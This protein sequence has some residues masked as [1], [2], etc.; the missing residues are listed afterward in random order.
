MKD[1]VRAVQAIGMLVAFQVGTL[2]LF[3]A[4]L[5]ADIAVFSGFGGA[6][7]AAAYVLLPVTVVLFLVVLQT[8]FATVRPGRADPSGVAV[9]QQQ[10]PRL[11]ARA[12][13]IAQVAGTRPPDEI[14]IDHAPNA[15]VGEGARLLGLVPGR[16]RLVI[17]APLLLGLSPAEFDAVL[18]HEFGH[19][20]NRDTRLT[21]TVNRGRAAMAAALGATGG[22]PWRGVNG[23]PRPLPGQAL[24][25]M[26]VRA[27][28]VRYLAVTKAIGRRQEY[29]ADR[30]AAELAGPQ[31]TIAALLQ[32][33]ALVPM[34]RF[35]LDGFALSGLDLGLAPEPGLFFDGFSALITDPVRLRQLDGLRADPPAREPDRF[36]S[37]PPTGDRIA[38]LRTPAPGPRPADG[39]HERAVSILTD[40]GTVLT[41][42]ARRLLDELGPAARS[43]DWDTLT[44]AVARRDALA[45]AQPLCDAVLLMTLRPPTLEAFA[46]LVDAGRFDEVLH[47]LLTPAQARF[48]SDPE[49]VRELAVKTLR[50]SL[51]PWLLAALAESGRVRWELSWAEVARPLVDPG[52]A[53]GLGEA[54]DALLAAAP[55]TAP[56]RALLRPHPAAES[57]G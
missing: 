27:Y 31:A 18:G 26:L 36:D 15:S 51:P 32:I 14:R 13:E 23:Q 16:R 17:G 1:S 10:Q 12:R 43:V 44:D 6:A 22:T 19:Y 46:D 41:A 55:D 30:I 34:Y 38:A 24:V 37:H 4:L 28:A 53:A 42:V 47:R 33:A 40:P 21:P 25:S 57:V 5:A 11:W 54:F 39:P 20:G 45:A 2:G 9:T 7:L 52:L 50:S 35:Y 29:A 48:A 56:L 49:V 3:A 8:V